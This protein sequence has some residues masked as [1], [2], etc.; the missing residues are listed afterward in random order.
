LPG[1]HDLHTEEELMRTNN[2]RKLVL[3]SPVHEAVCA[4]DTTLAPRLAGLQGRRLGLLDNSK[5]NADRMLNMVASLLHTQYGFANII[6][7]RKP[8][9]SKPV[10]PAVIDAWTGLCDLAIVGVGD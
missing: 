5:N 10:D 3:V 2:V 4:T 6:R 7:H 1:G 9:A 8:S